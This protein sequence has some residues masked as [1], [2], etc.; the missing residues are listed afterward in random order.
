M[1]RL[2]QYEKMK[3]LIFISKYYT[4]FKKSCNIYD[5]YGNCYYEAYDSIYFDIR[6]HL[7]V[8]ISVVIYNQNYLLSITIFICELI[9]Y[10]KI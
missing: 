10:N 1:H 7:L 4:V 6:V 8:I 2:L 5:Y 9:Q 3:D